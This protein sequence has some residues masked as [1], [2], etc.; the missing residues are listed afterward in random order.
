MRRSRMSPSQ[1]GPAVPNR[2]DVNS[3]YIVP[4]GKWINLIK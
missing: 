3:V 4:E 1:N 2:R